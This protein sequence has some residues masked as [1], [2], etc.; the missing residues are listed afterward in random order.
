MRPCGKTF[1]SEEAS[2][3][4]P[5]GRA[6]AAS[7]KKS[8]DPVY[9]KIAPVTSVKLYVPSAA[10]ESLSSGRMDRHAQYK[11]VRVEKASQE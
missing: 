7:S 11:R 2:S 3:V 8:F 10:P 5:E 1:Q 4:R 6:L 9:L